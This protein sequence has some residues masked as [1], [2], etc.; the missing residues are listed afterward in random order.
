MTALID[1]AVLLICPELDVTLTLEAILR[2]AADEVRAAVGG[3]PE[4]ATARLSLS[5]MIDELAAALIVYRE[6][7]ISSENA[8]LPF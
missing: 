8:N 5:E 4:C 7:R 2:D 1:P 6:M 3:G